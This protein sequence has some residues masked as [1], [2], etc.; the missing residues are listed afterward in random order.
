M[1]GDKVINTLNESALHK[2]L[3]VLYCEESGGKYEV[4]L[5][6]YT[7][8]V[9]TDEGA[10][11]EI[12]TG[13]L[14]PLLPKVRSFLRQ[15]RRVRVVYPL[16][17]QKT[18]VLRDETTGEAVHHRSPVHPSVYTA[19]RAARGLWPVLADERFSLEIVFVKAVEERK[20]LPAPVQSANG[21]RR[22]KK[23]WLKCGKHLEEILGR[24]VFQGLASYR[25]LFP[26]ALPARFTK[27]DFSRALKE[28]GQSVKADDASLFLWTMEKS[29]LIHRAPSEGRAIVYE[30]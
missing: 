15:G 19:F 12:Q 8:D 14:S 11:I 5:G 30:F 22:F 23:P 18:I 7:A 3:K 26:P 27:A 25:K 1:S 9:V 17:M 29:G 4:A 10:V 28:S 21:R 6:S 2:A 13:S 16:V 20:R 24:A